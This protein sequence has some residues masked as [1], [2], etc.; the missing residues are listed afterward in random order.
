MSRWKRIAG[1]V[2][3]G[4]GG[5]VLLIVLTAVVVLQTPW[6]RNYVRTTISSSVAKSTGGRVD[7]EAFS[8]NVWHLHATIENFVI[9]GKEPASAAPFVSIGKAEMRIRLFTSVKRLY[10]IAYLGVDR[11]AV[12][13]M[14]LPD[15][16][17][18][19]PSPQEKTTSDTTPL[20]TVVDLA[21]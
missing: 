17:T 21:V 19:I 18:N 20:E 6:F 3:M 16:N 10:E 8:F 13:I 1:Y 12:N 5:L 14:V 2:A 7:I 9:H 4:L 15:G 11:P